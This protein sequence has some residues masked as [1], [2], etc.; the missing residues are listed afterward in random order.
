MLKFSREKPSSLQC[1]ALAVEV[2]CLGRWSGDDPSAEIRT[3]FPEVAKAYRVAFDAGQVEPG[4]VLAVEL[5]SGPPKRCFLLP[6]RVHPRGPARPEYSESCFAELVEQALR[7]GLTSLGLGS[8]SF[9]F[10]AIEDGSETMG[11]DT[12]LRLLQSFARV[13]EIQL[14][15]RLP[16][17][18]KNSNKPVTIFTDGGAEPNPGKG[19][20]G[21]VLRFG[22]HAKELCGGFKHTSN[23]RME[24]LAAIAGLE[25]LKH[26]CHVR[27]HSDSRYVVDTVNTGLLFR[28]S[29]KSWQAKKTKNVDLWQRF[30][31][32]YLQH[33]VE[34]VWVKGHA[35]I[36]DNER[37]DQLAERA[38]RGKDLPA[39]DGFSQLSRKPNKKTSPQPKR[40]PTASPQA[41]KRHPPRPK[42][43]GDLCRHCDTPLIRREAKKHKPGAAYHFAWH[44]YCENCHRMYQV[45]QAK[46][47][48]NIEP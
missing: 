17:Q 12:K 9:G 45:E 6:L 27:L 44:L 25:A 35:G 1:D 38:M 2:N 3:A 43:P 40:I 48:R 7:I 8:R 15:G 14:I 34:M 24:L 21:V 39:D 30:L 46:V 26:P 19:G 33:D 47:Y 37:C 29:A 5:T 20:Y 41:T 36:E 32:S 4:R 18:S 13:P 31:K 16:S 22:D 28:L 11:C 23:N 10:G 42:L